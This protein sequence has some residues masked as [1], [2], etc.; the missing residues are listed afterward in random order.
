MASKRVGP[1]AGRDLVCPITAEKASVMSAQ[2]HPHVLRKCAFN[3][4]WPL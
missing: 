1:Y 4:L 3:C 2:F